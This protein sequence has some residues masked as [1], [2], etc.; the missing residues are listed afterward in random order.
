MLSVLTLLLLLSAPGTRQFVSQRAASTFLSRSRRANHVFEETRQGHLERECV[1]EFCSME[2]AREVFE[3]DPE[4]NYF[5]PKYRECLSRYGPKTKMSSDLETCVHN[6]PNQCSPVPC[7]PAG[8][9]R[10]EDLKG[11]FK[12]V[13]KQGWKGVTCSVDVDECKSRNGGCE[14]ICSNVEGSYRC[15]CRPGFNLLPDKRRC[16][17]INE[18]ALN[19]ELCGLARCVNTPGSYRCSCDS[20]YKYESSSKSCQDIDECEGP[21]CAGGCVNMAGKYSCYCDGK[22]ELKLAADMQNC[23]NIL[24]CVSL[25]TVK[26]EGSLYLGRFFQGFPV[27]YFNFKRKHQTRFSVEFDFR[28]FDTEGTIFQAGHQNNT[29]IMLALHN[30]KLQVQ[31]HNANEAS[32]VTTGGPLVNDGQWHTISVEESTNS[33]VVKVAREAVMNINIPQS[34][35]LKIP[36]Q[37]QI[38][39]TVGGLFTGAQLVK[40]I[41][42]RLDA[43]LR[44]WNWMNSEDTIRETIEHDERMQCF[45]ELERGS[46]YPGHGLASFLLNY[47]IQLGAD[48]RSWEVN[49]AFSIRPSQDTGVLVALVNESSVPLSLAI[50]D[51]NATT[52]GVTLAI[53]NVVVYQLDRLLLCAGDRLSIKL[54]ATEGRIVLESSGLLGSSPL[55]RSQLAERLSTLDRYMRGSVQTYV[56]GVPDVP[57]T[58]APVTAFYQ[59]CMDVYVND[60]ALDLDKAQYK[61]NDIRSHSCPLPNTAP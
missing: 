34:L 24:P 1:E 16:S 35:F 6:I 40:Q 12:C 32:G 11:A 58:A 43:C 49:F 26:N 23:V 30:G 15:S 31:Y 36:G 7:H 3:N 8:F 25:N 4:T 10:C 21:V 29:W 56:G 37:F 2:E 33:L 13:C 53:E 28:T 17:D 5:Y 47:D 44:G 59:G 55:K 9:E 38:D 57:I 20:G 61:H 39:I 18:C 46:Y 51:L 41:N 19:A 27:L 22:R 52:K 14:H 42:P 54:I 50:I 48:T 45:A 60:H